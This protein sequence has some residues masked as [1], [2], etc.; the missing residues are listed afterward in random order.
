MP[1]ATVRLSM[2][3]ARSRLRGL[4]SLIGS[5]GSARRDWRERLLL[6]LVDEALACVHEAYLVK[7]RGGTDQAGVSWPPRKDQRMGQTRGAPSARRPRVARTVAPARYLPLGTRPIG[8]RTGRLVASFEPGNHSD[9]QIREASGQG[10]DGGSR[11]PYGPH[12]ARVRPIVPDEF[13]EPWLERLADRLAREVVAL[14]YEV[15]GEER[16]APTL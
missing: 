4:P 11:V 10:A 8:V 15:L 1:E 14:T 5:P 16:Q 7:S 6:A 13:P 2:E 12:F 9:D 3:E